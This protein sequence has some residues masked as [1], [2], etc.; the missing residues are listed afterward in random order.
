[1]HFMSS[2]ALTLFERGN[3][4]LIAIAAEIDAQC[5][6][7]GLFQPGSMERQERTEVLFRKTKA[8]FVGS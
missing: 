1:M 6:L 2:K 3:D 4:M 7:P 8:L 5:S